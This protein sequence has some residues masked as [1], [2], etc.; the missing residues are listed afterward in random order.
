V[1]PTF[2]K[3]LR[4]AFAR[5]TGGGLWKDTYAATNAAEYWAEGVQS[6]FDCN[7]PPNAGV[8]NDVNTREKL[9]RYDPGLFELIDA[10]FKQSPY[11]YERY[12]KRQK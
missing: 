4:A 8:H 3:K 11:R 12:D 7:S 2:D 1:D 6:Y 5:A 10:A 9:A